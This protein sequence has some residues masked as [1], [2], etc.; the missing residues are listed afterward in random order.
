MTLH[1]EVL[2]LFALG[3][4]NLR[5]LRSVANTLQERRLTGVRSADDENSEMTNA[6][7]VLFDCRRIQMNRLG[8][9][10]D[11][12][13]D[14]CIHLIDRDEARSLTTTHPFS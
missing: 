3:I 7:K 12:C 9:V 1:D 5:E 10:F 2:D 8:H 13:R 11:T 4:V 14:F 6:I